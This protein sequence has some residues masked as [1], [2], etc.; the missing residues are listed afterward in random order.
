[1]RS[2]QFAMICALSTAMLAGS[3]VIRAASPAAGAPP[4]EN[5][6]VIHD[7]HFASGES[8]PEL[9]LHYTTLGKLHRDSHGRADNA[10]LILHGTG[11]SGHSLLSE[12]FAGV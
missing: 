5:D 6:Y 8:L 7:F 10:V 3:G 2:R 12:H 9:R 1:M 11:G 4:V